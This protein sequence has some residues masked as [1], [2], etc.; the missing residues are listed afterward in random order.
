MKYLKVWTSFRDVIK[1]LSEAEKGRLFDMMLIYT[2]TGEE[3]GKFAGN[4]MY[5]W[6]AAKQMIDLMVAENDRLKKNGSRG[7]RPSKE[8]QEKPTETKE[9]QPK[10]TET[11]KEKKRK[12]IERNEKESFLDDDEAAEIQRD[13]DRVLAAA[14]DAGFQMNNYVRAELI[15]LYAENG[16]KV[17]EAI[18]ACPEHGASNLA[19]LR[20]VLKGEP[21]KPKTAVTAQTYEQRDYS[22]EQESA[23]QRM[24]RLVGS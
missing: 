10:P 23:M 13:H 9:N 17:L 2:E 20:G 14:E 19:Y 21:R 11:Q 8:N 6:P 1:P 24:L 5:T 12:E 7:G 3:P 4:E 18:K 22:G 15:S 16:E